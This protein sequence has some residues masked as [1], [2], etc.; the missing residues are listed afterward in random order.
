MTPEWDQWKG[1]VDVKIENASERFESIEERMR[2]LE[3]Q[4]GDVVAKLSVPLFLAGISGPIIGAIIVYVLTK[5][6]K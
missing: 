2:T 6:A 3:K 5:S 4:V 1:A